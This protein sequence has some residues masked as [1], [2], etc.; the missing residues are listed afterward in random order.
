MNLKYIFINAKN[1]LQYYYFQY[2]N[3]CD[4]EKLYNA[5][6]VQYDTLWYSVT[7]AFCIKVSYNAEIVQYDTV[8]RYSMIH[9]G[10]VLH[11]A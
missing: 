9:Y 7:F 11:F 3:V 2:V 8:L 1:V 4:I 6:I 10:T 5:E